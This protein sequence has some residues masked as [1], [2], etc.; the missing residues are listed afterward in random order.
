VAGDLAAME[1]I[2]PRQ[3][4]FGGMQNLDSPWDT[5]GQLLPWNMFYRIT[6][7]YMGYMG[8]PG[9]LSVFDQRLAPIPDAPGYAVGPAGLWRYRDE[10]FSVYSFQR[11]VLDRVVPQIRLEETERPAQFR[12]RISDIS[13]GPMTPLLNDLGYSRTRRTSLGNIYLMQTLIQQLHVPG[14]SA[15]KAAEMLL[16][17]RLIC[18]LGG[19]YVY[20]KTHDGFGYWTS[21]ALTEGQPSGPLRAKASE[22]Y[23]TPPLNWFR[24]LDLDSLLT[25]EA[26]TVHADVVMQKPAKKNGSGTENKGTK[27]D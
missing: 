25:P 13:G 11:P 2:L 3:R 19:E 15:R 5:T 7:G 4:L 18:P 17:A 6:Q 1:M 21:T 22:G 10:R 16:G 8:E 12:L 9:W 20:Q 24:G 23:Q 14:E 26:V 27:H